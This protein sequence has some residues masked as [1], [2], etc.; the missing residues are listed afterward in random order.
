MTGPPYQASRPEKAIL[1]CREG[2]GV[3]GFRGLRKFLA[4]SFALVAALHLL[5]GHWFAIQ[6]MAWVTM[7]VDFSKEAPL[8]EAIG[9]TFDGEHPCSL[10][11][12]VAEGRGEER[13][14]QESNVD[15]NLKLVAILEPRPEPAPLP[16]SELRYF[17]FHPVPQSVD[18]MLPTPPP[19]AV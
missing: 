9:K 5:G 2:T 10:C 18:P 6:G 16:G 17:P 12:A 14:Q 11:K 15:P 8:A 13:K 3:L 1:T 19:W 7:V 4:N